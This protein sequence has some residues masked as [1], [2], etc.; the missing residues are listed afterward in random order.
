MRI[1]T[2]KTQVNTLTLTY[3]TQSPQETSRTFFLCFD[4]SPCSHCGSA[5]F[6]DWCAVMR[7][8]TVVEEE[9]VGDELQV[10]KP[11][12]FKVSALC[13]QYSFDLQ[14][15]DLDETSILEIVYI[16]TSMLHTALQSQ[17]NWHVSLQG[18]WLVSSAVGAQHHEITGQ[19]NG[20]FPRTGEVC[21]QWRGFRNKFPPGERSNFGVLWE[22][23]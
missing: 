2:K 9:T 16:Y 4:S 6:P 13:L 7:G 1:Y 23:S 22:R 8:G 3:C 20:D 5:V 17:G 10:K 15:S 11:M 21:G 12:R 19:G 18:L 14:T